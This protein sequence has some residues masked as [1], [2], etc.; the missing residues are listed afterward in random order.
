MALKTCVRDLN[1]EESQGETARYEVD[2]GS[3]LGEAWL[4][5]CLLKRAMKLVVS[6]NAE[7]ARK[8]REYSELFDETYG[9]EDET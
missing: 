6:Q 8:R 9:S 3:D 5:R 1:I 4:F 7:R 2:D